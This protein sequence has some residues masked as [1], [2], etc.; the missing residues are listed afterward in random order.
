MTI[1]AIP[2]IAE[3]KN[4]FRF[5]PSGVSGACRGMAAL[6]PSRRAR[7]NPPTRA[8]GRGRGW[9]E[10]MQEEPGPLFAALVAIMARLRGPGGCPW[11]REQS[12]SSI[13]PYLLEETYEVL[14][15]IGEGKAARL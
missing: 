4:F 1:R 8:G 12:P 7:Y 5:S 2:A 14:E 11:D 10:R 3:M 6:S 9:E 15:A 13:A